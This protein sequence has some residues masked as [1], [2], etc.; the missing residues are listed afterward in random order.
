[1]KRQKVTSVTPADIR[2]ERT[3][4]HTVSRF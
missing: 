3:G 4:D 1:V 2:T